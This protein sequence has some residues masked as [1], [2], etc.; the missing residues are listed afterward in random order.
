MPGVTLD[1]QQ[2]IRRARDGDLDAYGAL[3]R[4]HQAAAFRL[5]TVLAGHADAE[6]IAQSAF[7]K[8]HHGLAR[9]RDGAGFQ[10]WLLRIV[11]NEARNTVRARRRRLVR[12]HRW[13]LLP[14][15]GEPDAEARVLARERDEALWRALARLGSRDREVLGCRYLLELSVEETAAA[16]GWP[17]GTVKSRQNRALRRLETLLSKEE[18]LG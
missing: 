7:V 15:P 12:D 10:P 8:A 5:A 2:L 16:L 17:A 11:A 6:D 4:A 1:E 3:V 9:F 18:V 14:T 13:A